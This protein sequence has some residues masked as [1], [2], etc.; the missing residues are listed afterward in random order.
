[1]DFLP[2][3]GKSPTPLPPVAPEA[4]TEAECWLLQDRDAERAYLGTLMGWNPGCQKVVTGVDYAH[5]SADIRADILHVLR[6][7]YPWEDCSNLG[8]MVTASL[9]T[10][11]GYKVA[12]AEYLDCLAMQEPWRE[13]ADLSKAVVEGWK[14][15]ERLRL[16]DGARAVAHDSEAI[17]ELCKRLEALNGM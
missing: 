11:Y 2:P 3:D 17:A 1:M 5:F 15:R 12:T 16:L 7:L 9:T 6:D 8:V 13:L 10:R 14:R 4:F